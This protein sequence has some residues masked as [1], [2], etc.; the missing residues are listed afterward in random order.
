MTTNHTNGHEWIFSRQDAKA[1]RDFF[2]SRAIA[3]MVEGP[4]PSGPPGT[5]FDLFLCRR[6][7]H[8]ALAS[9]QDAFSIYSVYPGFRHPFGIPSPW[10]ISICPLGIGHPVRGF[11]GRDFTR[12]GIFLTRNRRHGGGTGSVRSAR[13]HGLVYFCAGARGGFDYESHEWARMD[14]DY[15]YAG[16]PPWWRDRLRPVRPGH[17]LIYFRAGAGGGG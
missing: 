3:A 8:G 11:A 14:L 5:W 13:G 7:G 16:T 9:L 15:F 2:G 6:A 4:A 17:G 10:A 12:Q 1:R